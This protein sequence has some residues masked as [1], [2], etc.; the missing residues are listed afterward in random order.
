MSFN[1]FNQNMN[2]RAVN[3]KKNVELIYLNPNDI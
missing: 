1:K 2:Y 3:V